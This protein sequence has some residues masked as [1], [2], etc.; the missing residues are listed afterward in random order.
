MF[1]TDWREISG[2]PNVSRS[3]HHC[4]VRSRHRWALEY[5]WAA[6]P[7]RS[8]TNARAIWVKPLF[9]APTRL[10]AGTATSV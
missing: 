4:A 5:A 7:M 3:R 2:R 8:E 6:R 10:V 9:S 1:C